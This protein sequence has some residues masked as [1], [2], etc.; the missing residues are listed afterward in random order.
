MK[1]LFLMRHAT[2]DW[3]KHIKTDL[4]RPLTSLGKIEAKIIA[5]RLKEKSDCIDLLLV[6]KAN[7][8]QE[9]ASFI[10]DSLTVKKHT[11]TKE[12]YETTHEKLLEII[13][14]VSPEINT[15]V[16]LAHNPSISMLTTVLLGIYEELP[17]AV[18]VEIHFD[19]DNWKDIERSN[20][21]FHNIEVPSMFL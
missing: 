17:P 11:V 10:C 18:L 3:P 6:S 21:C 9:T 14:E 19:T 7:R 1:K 12:I 20:I 16:L 2:S 15:L 5:S 13:Y 4:E 8:T